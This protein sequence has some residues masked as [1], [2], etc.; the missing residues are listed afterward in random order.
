M[1]I[2]DRL[3]ELIDIVEDE[4]TPEV[5]EDFEEEDEI[6][7][8]EAPKVTTKESDETLAGP[9]SADIPLEELQELLVNFDKKNRLVAEFAQISLQYENAKENLLSL[10]KISENEIKEEIFRIRELCDLPPDVKYHLS[11]P[12]KDNP[13]GR[14]TRV[15]D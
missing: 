2:K 1:S 6:V 15:V 8:D 12:T 4:E 13:T 14:F 3:Q 11:L 10:L 9:E 5:E 7:E